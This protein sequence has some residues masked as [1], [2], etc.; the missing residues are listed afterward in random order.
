MRRGNW[1]LA[2]GL[3]LALGGVALFTRPLL[4]ELR[5]DKVEIALGIRPAS[6]PRARIV[7]ESVLEAIESGA[8][9]NEL[10]IRLD[11]PARMVPIER[12]AIDRCEVRQI[13]YERF[14]RWR[15]NESARA[16]IERG[17]SDSLPPSSPI[18][19][20]ND[21]PDPLASLSTGHRIAGLLTSPA[22][23]V[24]LNAAVQYCEA[25]GGRL[26][27]AEE[28]E[29]A[30]GGLEGR[31]YAWGDDFDPEVWPY[32]D[33]WRNSSRACG[34]HPASDSPQGVHDLNGNAMEWSMGSFAE[35]SG[36][37]RPAAHGAPAVRATARALY[38]L[39][40]LWIRIE[41]DLRS[42]HLGFRCVY[43][44]APPSQFPWG[45]ERGERVWIDGGDH[46]IGL[47]LDVRL[48]RL[49]RLLP[50]DRLRHA[51]A[52]MAAADE[53]DRR[54]RLGR[55]EVTRR[56]YRAFLRDPL[57]RAGLFANKNEPGGES[58][59][60]L[61]WKKQILDPDLP[62]FGISWWAADAFARWA[63][64]RLPRVDEWQLAATGEAGSVYPWGNEYDPEAAITGDL[65]Q[66]GLQG[67]AAVQ[68]RDVTPAGVKHLAGNVSEWTQS[69]SVDGGNYAM[70]V[71][72]G[73]WLLPGDIPAQNTFGRLVPL[74]Y[75]ARGVGLR[76]VY[77]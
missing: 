61:E 4:H 6:S 66:A 34:S 43:D 56:E 51:R 8:F 47:P 41:P 60:P 69:I 38:A 39:N 25:V 52:M 68:T 13:D 1:L 44:N 58:Y 53:S 31:L 72:G 77:D 18:P 11:R 40:S 20:G 2:G 49:A 65:P 7:D 23:G 37:L 70:W 24:D 14:V 19:D 48:A 5:A 64:G 28:L 55:C 63:G 76:L 17:S 10:R 29:A 42:H 15:R 30:A 21:P 16:R 27:W 3:A 74:N 45:G 12:F 59:I 54:I 67:C 33:S 75:R 32:L 46:P 57:A 26:P 71:Q 73:N 50:N 35:P 9:G 62:V 36:R 22:T